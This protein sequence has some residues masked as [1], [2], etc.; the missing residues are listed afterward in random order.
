[1]TT[2]IDTTEHSFQEGYRHGRLAYHSRTPGAPIIVE[3]TEGYE[4]TPYA[5]AYKRGYI[6]AS[7]DMRLGRKS[8]LDH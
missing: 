2:L 7:E 3:F 6:T 5:G 1:M 8:R 4:N